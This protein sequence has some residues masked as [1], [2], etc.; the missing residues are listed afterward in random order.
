MRAFWRRAEPVE[1]PGEVTAIGKNSNAALVVETPNLH[2]ACTRCNS[3][4]FKGAL[5]EAWHL[6]FNRGME[7]ADG[8]SSYFV[9]SDL[10]EYNERRSPW[11]SLYDY[12]YRK[13][14]HTLCRESSPYLRW[15]KLCPPCYE[16]FTDPETHEYLP[17]GRGK[18]ADNET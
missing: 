17:D 9:Y 15:P 18:E 2:V 6:K 11:A 3:V 13:K 4:Y 12:K 8:N 14:Y 1:E 16:E 7:D 10:E 5:E